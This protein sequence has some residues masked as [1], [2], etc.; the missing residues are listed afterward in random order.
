MKKRYIILKNNVEVGEGDNDV[1]IYKFL[2]CTKQYYHQSLKDK[3]YD[4]GVN[5]KG[6]RYTLI[7]RVNP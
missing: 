4:N 2:N 7:D 5:Y 6:D 3:I 1:E